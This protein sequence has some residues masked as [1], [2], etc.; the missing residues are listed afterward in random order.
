MLDRLII[1]ETLNTECIAVITPCV[2]VQT[3]G[4]IENRPDIVA[5]P[6]RSF[7]KRF[8]S[9]QSQNDMADRVACSRGLAGHLTISSPR[10]RNVRGN[11]S[12]DRPTGMR[13]TA[14]DY[15]H[16]PSRISNAHTLGLRSELIFSMLSVNQRHLASL[17]RP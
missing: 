11:W 2:D 10:S 4:G 3:P 16:E 12:L 7:G 1:P 17:R 8:G 15:T 9:R 14:P 13:A 5:A 6:Q